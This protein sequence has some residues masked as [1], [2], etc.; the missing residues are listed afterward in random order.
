LLIPSPVI[1]CGN[2]AEYNITSNPLNSQLNPAA[3]KEFLCSRDRSAQRIDL[4]FPLPSPLAETLLTVELLDKSSANLSSPLAA[5]STNNALPMHGKLVETPHDWV[6][7][8]N[9]RIATT[10]LLR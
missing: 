10:H 8:R 7:L 9:P 6:K 1:S 2:N 4:A 5:K 3:S